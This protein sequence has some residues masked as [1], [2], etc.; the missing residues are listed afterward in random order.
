MGLNFVTDARDWLDR[1]GWAVTDYNANDNIV[2]RP[3]REIMYVDEGS[4]TIAIPREKREGNVHLKVHFW[5]ALTDDRPNE[6]LVGVKVARHRVAGKSSIAPRYLAVKAQ[7][8]IRTSPT[9]ET[10]EQNGA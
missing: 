7:R 6:A 5:C 10:V 9:K 2:F 1:R 8:W 4:N 3:E